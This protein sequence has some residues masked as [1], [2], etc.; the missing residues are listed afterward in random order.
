MSSGRHAGLSSANGVASF[1]FDCPDGRLRLPDVT[2][3]EFV[4]GNPLDELRTPLDV[5]RDER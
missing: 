5:A 2:S 1:I 4:F 3:I